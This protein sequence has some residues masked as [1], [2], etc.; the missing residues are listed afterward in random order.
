M[1]LAGINSMPRRLLKDT[2]IVA[3]GTLLLLLLCATVGITNS[4]SP[5]TP[6]VNAAQEGDAAMADQGWVR[7]RVSGPE[8]EKGVQHLLEP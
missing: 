5:S 2:L 4:T 6:T 7:D 1:S 8:E 3:G